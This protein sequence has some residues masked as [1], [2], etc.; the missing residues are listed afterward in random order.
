MYL[1]TGRER[2]ENKEGEAEINTLEKK[3]HV[4]YTNLFHFL[5]LLSIP[6]PQAVA[7]AIPSSL[8][9]FSTHPKANLFFLSLVGDI[10]A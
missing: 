5:K 3:E 2:G 1:P 10:L 9:F 8:T 6:C 7:D 4:S